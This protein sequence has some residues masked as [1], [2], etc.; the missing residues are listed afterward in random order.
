[1]FLDDSEIADLRVEEGSVPNPNRRLSVTYRFG[2]SSL[3]VGNPGGKVQFSDGVL[4][5][6]PGLSPEVLL[7]QWV[8]NLMRQHIVERGASLV[9]ASAVSR[10]N[11][12]YLFP[13]WAHTGKTNVG[14]SFLSSGFDY[15]ADDWC[16]VSATG[17]ILA[18]P[19]WLS[20]YDYNFRC[21]PHLI[22]T[23]GGP[24]EQ[25]NIRR[26]L[27]A[28]RFG[29]SL[30]GSNMLSSA[31]SR[32]LSDRYFVHARVPLSRA[33]PESRISLRAP[34]TKVCLLESAHRGG[35]VVTDISAEELA[36]K[37]ALC[38]SYERS[39]F[40]M[41]QLAIA[42]AGVKQPRDDLILA[43]TK[44]LMKA[45]QRAICLRAVLPKDLSSKNLDEIQRQLRET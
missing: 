33:M 21:F 42:Y 28:T 9:H 23:V 14:L 25:R 13:A 10:D 11:I 8:E 39:R 20:L 38:N 3:V 18:Y 15:M 32:R 35:G 44:L 19:R 4:R 17:E 6:E 7:V 12:G 31:L 27:A 40:R 45:F 22:R 34:L 36:Q 29:R 16:F 41:H 43:E 37:V 26:G 30:S 5:A 24:K 1:M 2:D